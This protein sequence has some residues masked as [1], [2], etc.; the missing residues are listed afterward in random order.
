MIQMCNCSGLV[1]ITNA[2]AAPREICSNYVACAVWAVRL[3]T[4]PANSHNNEMIY[5]TK[6]L[7][8]F[9]A[10]AGTSCI[11]VLPR[12]HSTEMHEVPAYAINMVD[13]ALSSVLH[14]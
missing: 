9:L 5:I 3:I 10:Y 12:A 6:Q 7:T 1:C 14:T 4:S 2:S 8:G 13:I 11:S